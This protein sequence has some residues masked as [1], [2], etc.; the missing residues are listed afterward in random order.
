MV[1]GLL[2]VFVTALTYS[3]LQLLFPP[4]QPSPARLTALMVNGVGYVVGY[5]LLSTSL[6]FAMLR[7]RLWD[8][9]IVTRRPRP[10]PSP[11]PA[12]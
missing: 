2:A 3:Y 10:T 5:G 8:I 4:W 9:D 6:L 7:F 12:R 11:E 1:G